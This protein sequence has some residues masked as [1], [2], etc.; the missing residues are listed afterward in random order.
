MKLA[1]VG[2]TGRVGA[3]ILTEALA[4][5]HDV[6]AIARHVETLAPRILSRKRAMPPILAH[7]R[8][9]LRVTTR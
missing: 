7:S 1:L 5:G 8:C 4:R 3:R 2:A 9:C 6:T